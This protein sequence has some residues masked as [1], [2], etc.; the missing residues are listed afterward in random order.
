M[1]PW[2]KAADSL[3][4]RRAEGSSGPSQPS[5]V[6]LPSPRDGSR[7]AEPEP[8]AVPPAVPALR[9]TVPA[10]PH[11]VP[12]DPAGSAIQAVQVALDRRDNGGD[13]VGAAGQPAASRTRQ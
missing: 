9:R 1:Y 3:Q 13:A 11:A 2:N 10:V 6:R 8:P 4:A 5:R 7:P 12:A